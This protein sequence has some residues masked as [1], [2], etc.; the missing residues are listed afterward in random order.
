MLSES[1]GAMF[2]Q[3]LQASLGTRQPRNGN[4]VGMFKK[5]GG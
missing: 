2:A 5:W 4:G 3:S 1:R